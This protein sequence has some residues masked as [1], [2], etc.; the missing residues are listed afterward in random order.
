MLRFRHV[1]LLHEYAP[2]HTSELVKLFLSMRY[3]LATLIILSR[4]RPIF[5]NFL[6]VSLFQ[7]PTSINQWLRGLPKSAYRI[8]EIES[9]IEIMY[10]K[11]R[12]ILW[13]DVMFKIPYTTHI[14]TIHI[15][16]QYTYQ[17]TLLK[18]EQR[19]CNFVK[20]T[21]WFWIDS[22]IV[23]SHAI[24]FF[25]KMLI[26]NKYSVKHSKHHIHLCASH[27]LLKYYIAMV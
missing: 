25:Q 20:C 10:F 12:E 3:C 11:S 8:S 23:I 5:Q 24:F 1:C 26:W 27:S 14:Y 9:E 15:S 4:Y 22:W 21:N 17:T 13:R 19:I 18:L 16:I 7:V 6:S 2:S